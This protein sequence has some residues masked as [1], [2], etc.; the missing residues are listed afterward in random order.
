MLGREGGDA[1][2]IAGGQSLMA[3]LNMRLAKPKTLIDI[4]RL[5]GAR[6]YRAQG[7]TVRSAR[8]SAR[9]R[10]WNG[11]TLAATCRWSRW[12]CRGPVTSRRGAGA[13]SADR[14]RMPIPAPNCRWCCWRSAAR[15]ICAAPGGAGVWRQGLLRRHDGDAARRRR[16]D[17]SRVVSAMQAS[18]ALSAKWRGVMAILRSSPA[19]RC[20][21][22]EGVRLAVGGVADMPVSA[23]VS[24]A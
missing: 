13:P 21:T 5:A 9:Q 17:R 12:R 24:A 2:I 18:A 11:P 10:C 15:C 7:G 3:M 8:A 22:D 4:M 6:A 19:L 1:R 14:S 20:A 16:I 23:G